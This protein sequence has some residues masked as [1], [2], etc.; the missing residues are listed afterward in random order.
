MGKKMKLPNHYGSVYKLSGN[1]RK[2]YAVCITTGIDKY[3][4]QSRKII[5]YVTDRTEGLAI[6]ADYHK[7]PYDIN[8]KDLTFQNVWF[9]VQK[10]LEELVN[11]EKM[12]ESNLTCLSLA[13]KNHCSLLYNEKLLDLRTKKMQNVID[14]SN[15]GHTGKGYI[16]TVCK[17]IFDYAILEYELPI[18]N[19][20]AD[21]LNV[22]ERIASDKHIPFTD[23]E[24]NILWNKS[25]NN[26]LIKVILIYCYSGMRPNEIFEI[27]TD[28]IYLD[29]RYMI[30]GSKTKAGRNRIIPIHSQI[31]PLIEYFVAKDNEY[32]FIL[33]V[34][35][36]NYSKFTR[37]FRNLMEEL[38]FNH[39]PHD[40]RHTF[41]TKMKRAGA[42]D[43]I[44]KR[45]V[46]HSITDITEK[47]Y[48]HREIEELLLE[49]ERIK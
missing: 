47:V 6:L 26:D 2:P 33:N 49:I 34:S 44:L 25:E 32:P 35:K 1:R 38:G 37:M 7:N 29:K 40:G 48:T 23:E 36:F 15:L 43:F 10:K 5:A 39:T 17:K 12:S 30:G 42:N 22:G 18:V 19:N 27:S 8:L 13:F 41:I 28:N 9:D 21:R 16:K 31:I 14:N 4:K 3:G 45:I 20:P 24:I 11:K 46:G